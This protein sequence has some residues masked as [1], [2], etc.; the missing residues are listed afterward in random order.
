MEVARDKDEGA[1]FHQD[2]LM[3]QKVSPA[4]AARCARPE[5]IPGPRRLRDL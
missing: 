3:Q 4:P 2:T 1:G 5:K